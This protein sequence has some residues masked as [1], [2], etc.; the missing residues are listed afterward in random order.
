[1]EINYCLHFCTGAEKS[2]GGR[3]YWM[4]VFCTV[5]YPV[6]TDLMKELGTRISTPLTLLFSYMQVFDCPFSRGMILA[7]AEW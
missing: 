7:L 4:K 2:Q 3:K 1:M 6:V 5:P